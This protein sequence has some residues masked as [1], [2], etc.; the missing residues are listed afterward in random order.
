VAGNATLR[1]DGL[2]AAAVTDQGIVVW[3]LDPAHWAEEAC[4]LAGRNMTR[5][6]WDR[7]LGD[8]ANY[9]ATCDQ[10]PAAD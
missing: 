9:R 10:Y 3:D 7:Y 2:A 4:E 5:E 6:E 1:P 8:L